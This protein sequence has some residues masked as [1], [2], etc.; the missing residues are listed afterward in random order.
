MDVIIV[1]LLLTIRKKER[2]KT[3]KIPHTITANDIFFRERWGSKTNFAWIPNNYK[4]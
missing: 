3:I 1:T 4:F 2:E